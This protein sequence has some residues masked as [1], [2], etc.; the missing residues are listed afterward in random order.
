MALRIYVNR[1]ALRHGSGERPFIVEFPDGRR[2][3]ARQVDAGPGRFRHQP[4]PCANG[5]GGRAWFECR[6]VI[7]DGDTLTDGQ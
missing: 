1:A 6:Q 7:A 2:R 3:T 5:C 4:A